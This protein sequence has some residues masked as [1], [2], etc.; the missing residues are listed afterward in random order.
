MST[1]DLEGTILVLTHLAGDVLPAYSARGLTQTLT[2][3]DGAGQISRSINGTAMNMSASQ[4]QK[5]ASKITCPD[6]TRVPAFDG[7]WPGD[8]FVMDCICE[9]SYPTSTGGAGP[10][11]VPGSERVEGDFTF[12]RPR[13]TMMLVAF[14]TTDDEW[15]NVRGW[16]TDWVEV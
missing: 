7:I 14:N 6:S 2:P 10:E 12:Y 15:P 4:F 11:V 5:Y 1:L 16:D 8:I 9:L 13:L 3:I